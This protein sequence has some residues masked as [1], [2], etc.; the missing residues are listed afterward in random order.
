MRNATIILLDALGRAVRAAVGL[1]MRLH[2]DQRGTISIVS[3]FTLLALVMLLGMV[4][5]TGQ[6]VDQKIRMQNAA[7]AATYSGGVVLTRSMNSL[8]FTNHL[9]SEVF[10]LTAFM[11]EAKARRAESLTPEML[12]NWE[13]IGRYMFTPSAFFKFADLGL[14]VNEKIPPDRAIDGDREMIFTFSEWAAAG[15]ELMLPVFEGI[16]FEELIPQFQ[17]DLVETTPRM[18]QI[19]TDEAARRHGRSWPQPV[20]LRGVLWRTGVDPVGGQSELSLGTLPVV[21]PLREGGN[22][23]RR[24]KAERDKLAKMYLRRWNSAVLRHFD[25]LGQMSQFSSLWRIFT[26]GELKS[27]L[28]DEY[29]DSNLPHV[30]RTRR[31]DEFEIERDYMFV[32]VVYRKKHRD[33]IPGVFRNPVEGDS[34]AFAQIMLFVPQRRLVWPRLWRGHE[35]GLY[36]GGIPGMP[37]PFPDLNPNPEQQP[38]EDWWRPVLQSSGWHPDRWSLFTQNWNVQMTPASA[39]Q[40]GAILVT[41]PYVLGDDSIAVPNLNGLTPQDIRWLNHH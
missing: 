19:A 35:G 39:E 27:L 18:V 8:A 4:M 11:R 15:S 21:D 31:P 23:L 40:L 2:C 1:P 34:T 3:V 12:D 6:Q 22:Y 36:G 20:Q 7:D 25:L 37:N 17:I 30:L 5:N 26:C 33:L 41:S 9:L 13:R 14:A 10:A 24:A 38:D 29:P 28:D 16:L 32:G